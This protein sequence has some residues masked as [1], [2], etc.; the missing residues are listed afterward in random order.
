MQLNVNFFM[1]GQWFFFPVLFATDV[2]SSVGNRAEE[3]GWWGRL[4]GV[5]DLGW[6]ARDGEGES[7]GEVISSL[8]QHCFS[9]S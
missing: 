9:A 6:G 4:Q 7:G 2:D 1:Y 3:V 8:G 5:A